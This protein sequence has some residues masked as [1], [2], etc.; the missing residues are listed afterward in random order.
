MAFK[1]VALYT[2]GACSKNPGPGGWCAILTY[3]GKE[4]IFSGGTKDTTNNIMELTAVIK[5][6]EALK[7]PCKVV[8]VT[9]SKYV[10]QGAESWMS[11]WISNGWK[12]K[13]KK[14]VKNVEHWKRLKDLLDIHKVDWIWVEGHSGD[15]YNERCDKIAKS[16]IKK[17]CLTEE[18]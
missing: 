12:T 8:V 11:G 16:E 18:K 6:L 15:E 9:D 14:A 10:L 17:L 3:R 4:K 2:D 7:E 5:G 1:E 13:A